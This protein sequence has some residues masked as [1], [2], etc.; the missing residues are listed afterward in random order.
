[1]SPDMQ[2]F[3]F[4]VLML[5]AGLVLCMVNTDYGEQGPW[6]ISFAVGAFFGVAKRP[7]AAAKLLLLSVI[8]CVGCVGPH[9]DSDFIYL[10]KEI[11]NRHDNYVMEDTT[12][13]PLEKEAYLEESAACK[14]YLSAAEK[15][16]IKDP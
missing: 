1:M 8:L 7:G 6:L 5:G 15:A 3:V 9:I 12:L 16:T 10:T 11:C 14:E 13:L 4:A 2:K